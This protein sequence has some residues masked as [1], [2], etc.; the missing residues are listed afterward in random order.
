MPSD[1]YAL[2]AGLNLPCVLPVAEIEPG[3][4]PEP[5]TEPSGD[6]RPPE[7]PTDDGAETPANAIA[8]LP[9]VTKSVGAAAKDYSQWGIGA[10]KD[11]WDATERPRR[12][13]RRFGDLR[14]KQTWV[15]ALNSL[16]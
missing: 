2:I 3:T 11:E 15:D 12:E 16:G 8:A 6:N 4:D 13:V 5:P 9:P 1:A 14:S 7:S 10:L